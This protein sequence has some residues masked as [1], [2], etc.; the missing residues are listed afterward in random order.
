M[1]ISSVDSC[2][3]PLPSAASFLLLGE[4]P[5]CFFSFSV[6]VKPAG[7]FCDICKMVV[8]YADKELEK[9]ATTTEIEALLEKVCHFLPESVSDQVKHL[10]R[11][12][13]KSNSVHSPRLKMKCQHLQLELIWFSL[14]I[15]RILPS[16][17]ST[18]AEQA[19][20]L[21]HSNL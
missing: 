2:Y 14:P 21:S 17:L 19:L 13:L 16:L 9:N 15:L 6:V 18:K 10:H 3:H 20:T 11:G 7:G 4:L 8:A 12:R 1:I 5:K